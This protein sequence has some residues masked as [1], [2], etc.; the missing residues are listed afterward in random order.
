V[1]VWKNVNVVQN[2]SEWWHCELL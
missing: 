2:I 1:E